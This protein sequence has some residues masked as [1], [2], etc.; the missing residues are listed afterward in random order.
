MTM[1]MSIHPQH[2]ESPMKGSLR[3]KTERPH[4]PENANSVELVFSS[5][6]D[7]ASGMVRPYHTVDNEITAFNLNDTDAEILATFGL[8]DAEHRAEL[9]PILR[10]LLDDQTAEA[11]VAL[12]EAS[13]A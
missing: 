10:H 8:L 3:F 11:V 12:E 9:I 5:Y 2:Y 4:R 6:E 13:D 7:G 1:K